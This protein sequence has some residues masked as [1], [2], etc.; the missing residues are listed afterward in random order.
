MPEELIAQYPAEPRD[1]SRLLVLD[2]NTGA[3]T[4]DVFHNLVDHLK[5][6]DVLV[7]NNS[8]V[9]PAR[10]IGK[11]PTG[12]RVEIFL[13]H[14]LKDSK[15]EVLGRNIKVGHTIS[16]SNS[17]LKAFVKD[18]KEDTYIVSFNLKGSEFLSELD[19]IGVV[20]LPPYIKRNE[21]DKND[22]ENYQTIYAKNEGSA[23]APTAGL[24]F[25]SELFGKIEEKGISV[26]EVTLHVGIGTFAP[27]KTE[28]IEEHKI[29]SEYYSID[30]NTLEMIVS[31]KKNGRRI[32]AV[33]T[34][35]ARVL[36]HIFSQLVPEDSPVSY[37]GWTNIFIYPGYQFKC[38][39]GI[40]TNFHLPKSSLLML[41]SALAGRDKIL[42][43]YEEAIAHRY[44]FF[45]Y[46]DG[47]LIT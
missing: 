42:N 32:I 1:S 11:K 40:I 29:H 27:V 19:K 31:A 3:I 34:T 38:I 2:K 22:R 12:G 28:N 37:S 10:L 30:N 8:K 20:P 17:S 39:D 21:S 5:A 45:S 16:F 33:G 44:R 7:T 35:T 18:K 23:A 25:T 14:E 26:L 36:E 4:H 9:I 43:A 6:G 15:W 47:M 46:G 13:N 41:I 24:H